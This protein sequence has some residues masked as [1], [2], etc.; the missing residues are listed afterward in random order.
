MV[1]PC[2]LPSSARSDETLQT[3]GWTCCSYSSSCFSTHPPRTE[4]CGTSL[5]TSPQCHGGCAWQLRHSEPRQL[6]QIC[7]ELTQSRK[8]ISLSTAFAVTRPSVSLSTSRSRCACESEC[9]KSTAKWHPRLPRR[10][11]TQ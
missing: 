10:G 9:S 3:T 4:P 6:C 11:Q 1:R 5:I 2:C 7:L 8:E